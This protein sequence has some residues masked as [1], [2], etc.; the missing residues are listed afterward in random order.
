MGLTSTFGLTGTNMGILCREF[1]DPIGMTMGRGIS[2]S[3]A[4]NSGTGFGIGSSG[5][6]GIEIGATISSGVADGRGRGIGISSGL[7]G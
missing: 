1:G 2:C 3:P 7:M 5:G 4:G 6:E